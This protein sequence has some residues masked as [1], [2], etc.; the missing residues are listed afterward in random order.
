MIK[1]G[2]TDINSEHPE[3]S[4]VNIRL[5][6][7]DHI[8]TAKYVALATGIMTQTEFEREDSALTGE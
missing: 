2:H 3:Q 1:Y 5:V 6:T 7:G 8:E 4:P